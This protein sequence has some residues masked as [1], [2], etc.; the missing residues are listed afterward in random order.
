MAYATIADLIQRYGED[1][2]IQRSDRRAGRIRDD[3]VINQ[4]LADASAEI[5]SYLA[6]RYSLPL[7]GVPDVLVRLCCDVARYRLWA[8]KVTEIVRTRYEDAVRQLKDIARGQATLGIAPEHTPLPPSV[9]VL[10]RSARR[11]FGN[12]VGNLLAGR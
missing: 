2:L 12:G 10:G 6:S 7:S 5:D 3:V 4:A 9:G 1:E 8:D 11:V